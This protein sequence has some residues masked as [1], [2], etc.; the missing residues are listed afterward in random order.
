[1]R[2]EKIGVAS[3]ETDQGPLVVMRLKVH[4]L[5][6]VFTPAEALELAMKL[7]VAVAELASSHVDQGRRIQ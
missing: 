6:L 1:M 5:T 4:G 7:E 3:G 2:D